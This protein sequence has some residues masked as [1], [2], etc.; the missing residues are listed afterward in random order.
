VS[1]G[2]RRVTPPLPA[3]LDGSRADTHCDKGVLTLPKEKNGTARR[4]A[5]S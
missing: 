2:T 3:D 5:V 1:R 4:I